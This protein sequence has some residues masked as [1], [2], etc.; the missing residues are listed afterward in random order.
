LFSEKSVGHTTATLDRKTW[1]ISES[2]TASGKRKFG[3]MA[4]R[5]LPKLLSIDAMPRH[6]LG[7]PKL[8]SIGLLYQLIQSGFES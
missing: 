8:G 5:R 2:E 6:G 3:A 7:N 4:T 1:R